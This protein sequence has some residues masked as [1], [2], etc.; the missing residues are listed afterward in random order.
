MVVLP[1]TIP[2]Q[3]RVAR[4]SDG[5]SVVKTFLGRAGDMTISHEALQ[6]HPKRLQRAKS[7][8]VPIADILKVD[9]TIPEGWGGGWYLSARGW[10][11]VLLAFG[12]FRPKAR[13]QFGVEIFTAVGL[14]AH[15]VADWP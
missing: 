3:V 12:G 11:A 5:T 1:V 4:R 10:N 2:C 7:F 14:T 13:Q 15:R 8:V 6:W 9:H